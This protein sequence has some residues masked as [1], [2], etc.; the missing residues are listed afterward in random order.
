MNSLINSLMNSRVNSSA[1]NTE[2]SQNYC[3]Y[4]TAGAQLLNRPTP[5]TYKAQQTEQVSQ[6][7]LADCK[8]GESAKPLSLL[9]FRLGQEWLALPARLCQQ[10]LSPLPFHTLPHRSNRTLL[11]IVNVRGQLL[12]KVCLKETLGLNASHVARVARPTELTSVNVYPRMVILEKTVDNHC[13]DIWAF[14]VD[15]LYGVH[16]VSL[17]QLESAAGMA[18]SEETCVCNV[19]A[20][21]EQ[22][23]SV[24]DD[25]RLFNA[26]RKRSL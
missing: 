13:A 12:L 23:V 8:Q 26:L 17:S 1:N 21:R 4:I 22:R 6:Q 18:S 19:F 2:D 14:D 9:V 10:I 15:E 20:W 25:D 11:G 7:L 24:L 5:P 16:S 3:A